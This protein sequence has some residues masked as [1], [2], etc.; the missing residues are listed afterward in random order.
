MDAQTGFI[1]PGSPLER[2]KW[3]LDNLRDRAQ[4]SFTNGLVGNNSRSVIHQI[5][6][7]GAKNG[8]RTAFQNRGQTLGNW[9][10][11]QEVVRGTGENKQLYSDMVEVA[12]WRTEV[13]NGDQFDGVNV[14]DLSLTQHQDAVADLSSIYV[15]D[16]DQ[17]FF[18]V[19][20]QSASHRIKLDNGFNYDA[21]FEIEKI[22]KA[23]EGYIKNES[24]TAINKR[25]AVLDGFTAVGGTQDAGVATNLVMNKYL[26]FIDPYMKEQLYKDPRFQTMMATADIRGNGNRV[27]NGVVGKVGS[28]II[29]EVPL[30][31][32][33]TRSRV[34]G[35]FINKNPEAVN[36]FSHQF[37]KHKVVTQGLRTYTADT[38]WEPKAWE[39]DE[40][41]ARG[42]NKFS[43]AVIVSAGAML[44]AVGRM[45]EYKLAYSP[46]YGITSGSML[47]VWQGFKARYLKAETG[48]NANI[49]G[50]SYG[51]VSV[52]VKHV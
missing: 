17:A 21:F 37:D 19:A 16:M 50:T 7:T 22:I 26:M 24:N 39:G 9:K 1:S 4:F 46:D 33:H 14:G 8:H 5:N 3:V 44:K 32:G 27:I 10:K 13:N 40:V 43:R 20:Q 11:D 52:D 29:V 31:M 42:A 6:E 35:D 2:Q 45:P 34:A 47:E 48:D 30:F 15:K 51:I 12:R 49:A 38:D 28:L 18:D 41:R 25:R 36:A 23:G